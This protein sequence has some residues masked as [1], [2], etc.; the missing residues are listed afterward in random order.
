MLTTLLLKL[1]TMLNNH[2]LSTLKEFRFIISFT[3]LALIGL[4]YTMQ[5]NPKAQVNILQY[6][7]ASENKAQPQAIILQYHHVSE[8]T[9]KST[10]ISPERFKEHLELIKSMDFNVLPLPQV[11]QQIRQGIPFESNTL[12]ITFDDGYLSI[13][14]NAFPLLQAYQWPFTI[15]VSPNAIDKKFGNSLSWEMLK[16]M[17][18]QGA[19]I[20][21]HSLAH[22]HLLKKEEGESQE[23]WLTRINTDITKA[24]S[25]LEAELN[26]KNKLLAYPYGE[27]DYHLKESVKALGYIAFS[28][29]S[30]PISS[31]SDFQSLA[32]FPASGP[33]AKLKTLK[34][35]LNSLA[36]RIIQ[37]R[38]ISR[39][40]NQNEPAPQLRLTVKAK[41]I[42]YKQLRCFY[43]GKALNVDIEQNKTELTIITQ[44]ENVL[45]KG[46]SRYNCTAPSKSSRAY[47]WYSMPF[48]V[49][50]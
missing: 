15:F 35:K 32:R 26:I 49:K 12:A 47:Y 16:E 22:D 7:H 48:V 40:L 25:R 17:K 33:Y 50:H 30:G 39:L 24:Q 31:S 45:S 13:Y 6:H 10:S 2:F 4:Y 41:D 11:I 27:F 46:R 18:R 5:S 21:N 20:A 8:H 44:A 23:S 1:K 9:P 36:F 43:N 19:T 38:P 28:Q 34:V 42:Q 3:L 37:E 29:Q 14:E